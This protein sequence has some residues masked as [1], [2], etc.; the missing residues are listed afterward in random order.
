MKSTN[1]ETFWWMILE[2]YS[3]LKGWRNLNTILPVPFFPRRLYSLIFFQF[4]C[5]LFNV[6]CNLR[7]FRWKQN[8]SLCRSPSH[9][10]WEQSWRRKIQSTIGI[11][12]LFPTVISRRLRPDAKTVR[13]RN[14]LA[15]GP[16]NL[17]SRSAVVSKRQHGPFFTPFVQ[18]CFFLTEFFTT[19]QLV[20][21]ISV[22]KVFHQ[23]SQS[24]LCWQ[25][26]KPVSFLRFVSSAVLLAVPS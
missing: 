22:F 20:P 12:L 17:K 5:L 15:L 13:R 26:A 14:L 6:I 18:V 16:K 3:E 23:L 10:K 11:G 4:I 1:I 8:S 25:I 7:K 24:R 2:T 21:E 9:Q 19:S